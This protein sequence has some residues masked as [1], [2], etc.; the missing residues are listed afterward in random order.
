MKT[1]I[2][3]QLPAIATIIIAGAIFVV[4]RHQSNTCKDLSLILT[5]EIT[6]ESKKDP[7]DSTIRIVRCQEDDAYSKAFRLCTKL[8]AKKKNIYAS[9]DVYSLP[10]DLGSIILQKVY[11]DSIFIRISFATLCNDIPFQEI[12]YVNL[13]YYD[14]IR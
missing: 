4:F 6:K 12:K 10:D 13:K 11:N 3:K 7:E 9:E 5:E 8:N 2:K 1:T 14:E